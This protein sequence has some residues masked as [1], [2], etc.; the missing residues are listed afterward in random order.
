MI[1]HHDEL[2]PDGRPLRAT[3]AIA[4]RGAVSR[5]TEPHRRWHIIVP[6]YNEERNLPRTIE[7]ATRSN[8]QGQITF[9]DDASTDRS[10]RILD[11]AAER[12]GIRVLHMPSNRKKEGAIRAAL[13]ALK[14]SGSLPAF[15]IVLDADSF[16]FGAEPSI[17]AEVERSISHMEDRDLSGMAFRIDAAVPAG[18]SLLQRCIYTDY[19]GSQ[20][21]NRI[22]SMQQQL[23]VINGPGGI[24]RSDEL[25]Q[26]LR[27]M[28]PDFETGDLLITLLLMKAGRRI[29]Y[30]PSLTVKTI[31]P[32]TYGEY[33]RQRRRW[34]RGT[35]KVLIQQS[36]FYLGLLV[37]PRLLGLSLVLHLAFPLGL[38]AMVGSTAFVEAPVAFVTATAGFSSL[39]WCSISMLKCVASRVLHVDCRVAP[40]LLFTIP[41]SILFLV[42]TGPARVAGAVDAIRYL[43]SER[44]RLCDRER[45]RGASPRAS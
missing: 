41:N 12:F 25:L 18:S 40:A 29:E 4:G 6:V 20:I 16:F 10:G 26:C 44:Q 3:T 32:R 31:V 28:V 43:A 14:K 38:I 1:E 35:L 15:T 42:A 22:T 27:E 9:V 24:F 13:E 36:R 21:D 23:W 45:S 2:A 33:F 5:P 8:Y 7:E 19:L 34:E 37:C 11:E 17:A 39:A 30:W